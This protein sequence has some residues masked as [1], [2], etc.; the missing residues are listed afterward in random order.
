MYLVFALA[1]IMDPRYK[2]K[3]LEFCFLKY[4][5]ND[6]LP[7]SSILE[8]IQ[9]LLDDCGAQVLNGVPYERIRF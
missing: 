1:T 3:Y 2:V 9:R 6:L 5:G 4:E 7:L 8:A